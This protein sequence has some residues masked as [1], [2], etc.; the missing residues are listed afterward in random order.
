MTYEPED[1]GEAVPSRLWEIALGGLPAGIALVD[2]SGRIQWI[3][4]A[5][6]AIMGRAAGDL[7]G[8]IAPFRLIR[9]S[10]ENEMPSE[11]GESVCAWSAGPQDERWLGYQEGARVRLGGEGTLVVFRDVTEQQTQHR[12]VA[13]LARTAAG[14]ASNGSLEEVLGAM[15]AEVQVSPGVAGTQIMTFAPGGDRLQL[16]GSAGFAQVEPFFE[17][18]M[19]SRDR[20]ADLATLRSMGER[21]QCVLPGRKAEMLADPR[22]EPMHDYVSQLAWEDFVSTPLISR[23]KPLGAL[24]V[25]LARGCP[26]NPAILEFLE[27]MAEQAA[28][29]VDYATL[30]DQERVSVRREERKRLGREL[31]DSV[32]QHV[33]SIGMQAKALSGMGKRLSDPLAERVRAAAAE[34]TGLV[35]AVQRDLRG[36]VLA[37]QPSVPAELGLSTALHTLVKGIER[38]HDVSVDLA[39]DPLVET[40][41]TPAFV[42]DVY[43]IVSEALHNAVKHA[44]P[45]EVGVDVGF[46]RSAGVVWIDVVDDGH[47]AAADSAGPSG[48]G[49]ISMRDR[50]G[51][52]G[53]SVT[54][55][56]EREHK[57][58]RVRAELRIQH[59]GVP[60]PQ[61]GT[62]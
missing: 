1:P 8:A 24:N 20:G 58:T 43:Q 33:F 35:D 23:D 54:I 55:A 34:V 51:R 47:G 56:P 26:A 12:R 59:G 40:M 29:A 36:V 11:T 22:W 48:F 61:E 45:S 7:A 4:P 21:R 49:L 44:A 52:W 38:R 62:A 53:G 16:M 25:Y 37:L 19:A 5:G 27:A 39:V 2:S 6:A 10:A 3:N 42:E 57:G 28:L 46:D 17:L 9:R 18:L 50:A 41:S 15:A 13:A 31:H 30:I 32:V 60:D 14:M